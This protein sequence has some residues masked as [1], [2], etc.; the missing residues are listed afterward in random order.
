ME[1]AAIDMQLIGARAAW[2]ASVRADF[3]LHH[4]TPKL[5]QTILE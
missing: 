5:E 4:V 1:L 2:D 3:G